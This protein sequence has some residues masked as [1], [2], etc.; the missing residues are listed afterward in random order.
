MKHLAYVLPVLIACAIIFGQEATDSG[1]VGIDIVK[2]EL[3]LQRKTSDAHL[4]EIKK[5]KGELEALRA[6]IQRLRT[7]LAKAGVDPE[8]A[9][10]AA[11]GEKPG[12]KDAKADAAKHP[13]VTYTSVKDI[14]LKIPKDKLPPVGASSWNSLQSKLASDWLRENLVGDK[15]AMKLKFSLDIEESIS[16]D[17]NHDQQT[18]R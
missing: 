1:K 4:K 12:D 2:A 15:L 9:K 14:F 3:K 18:G 13:P 17:T 16:N 5:L 6:E 11:P 7:L 8:S 10:E